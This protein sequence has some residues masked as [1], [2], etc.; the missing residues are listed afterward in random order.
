MSKSR[1]IERET[2]SEASERSLLMA[3]C[4]FGV[5]TPFFSS[6]I[7]LESLCL[8]RDGAEALPKTR[9]C[10]QQRGSMMK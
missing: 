6:H 4:L 3:L 8:S 10:S 2:D 1:A 5:A 7:L 9:T